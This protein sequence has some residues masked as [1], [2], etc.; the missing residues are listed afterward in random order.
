MTYAGLMIASRQTPF[1]MMDISNPDRA[2]IH[3]L[4]SNSMHCYLVVL[5]RLESLKIL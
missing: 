3:H 4:S 2:K 1:E 5:S